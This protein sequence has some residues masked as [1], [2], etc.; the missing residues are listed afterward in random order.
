MPS[1][2]L[3]D[4][5]RHSTLGLLG[6]YQYM[7]MASLERAGGAVGCV[8]AFAAYWCGTCGFLTKNT[9]GMR[10]PVGDLSLKD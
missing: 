5:A 6:G 8:T 1:C 10:L 4:L 7:Q 9:F 2:L 3:A